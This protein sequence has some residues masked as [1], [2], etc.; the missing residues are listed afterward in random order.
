M[1]P[2]DEHYFS[3]EYSNLP[4]IFHTHDTLIFYNDIPIKTTCFILTNSH[5]QIIDYFFPEFENSDK[6]ISNFSQ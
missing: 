2:T 5:F 6:F 1:N 4:N 3:N